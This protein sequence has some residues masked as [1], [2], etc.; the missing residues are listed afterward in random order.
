[1][2]DELDRVIEK[3]KDVSEETKKMS[4]SF[5]GLTDMTDVSSDSLNSMK[6][7]LKEFKDSISTNS[8]AMGISTAQT[9]LFNQQSTN[10][11]SLL[12]ALS[13]EIKANGTT[14]TSLMN[15]FQTAMDSVQSS[16]SGLMSNA[17][18]GERAEVLKKLYEDQSTKGGLMVQGLSS[19]TSAVNN[20]VPELGQGW[21]MIKNS[22]LITWAKSAT[23]PIARQWWM[24]RKERKL[25]KKRERAL[26]A[27]MN[28]E[29]VTW[30]TTDWL[31][32]KMSG[33]LGKDSWLGKEVSMLQEFRKKGMGIDGFEKLGAREVD[34]QLQKQISQLIDDQNTSKDALIATNEEAREKLA[35]EIEELQGELSVEVDPEEA[36]ALQE[37]ITAK[38]TQEQWRISNIAKQESQ[39]LQQNQEGLTKAVEELN[40]LTRG[41]EGHV[42]KTLEDVLEVNKE[43]F[44]GS[45]PYLQTIAETIQ[46]HTQLL[47]QTAEAGAGDGGPIPEGAT[48]DPP[49][50][51]FL[52]FLSGLGPAI[53][54]IP[55][56]IVKVLKGIGQ[57]IAG[58][59]KALGS[60]D[61]ASLAMGLAAIT[62]IALSMM[63]LAKALQIAGPVIVK[64]MGAIGKILTSV[65]EGY[66]KVIEA[67]GKVIVPILRAMA[68]VIKAVGGVVMKFFKGFATVINAIGSV[69]GGVFKGIIG[70]FKAIGTVIETIGRVI[71]T[72]GRVI[73][74][75][76]K[77]LVSS[78]IQLSEIPFWNYI[79]LAAAFVILGAALGIFGILAGVAV[80]PLIALG[81][82]SIGLAALMATIGDPERLSL[83]A[84][85]FNTLALAVTKFAISS[86][87][88][89]PALGIF[90]ALS[91]IPFIN[92]LIG[93]QEGIAK[94]QEVG[95]FTAET[96]VVEGMGGGIAQAMLQQQMTSEGLTQEQ[97]DIMPPGGQIITS[98]QTNI[99][100]R[101]TEV[102]VNKT[103]V[104]TNYLETMKGLNQVYA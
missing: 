59:F 31:F 36:A 73:I 67:A 71:V 30:D 89:I 62:G 98:N 16:A 47:E 96:L 34:T 14:T 35:S 93:T 97:G 4:D 3:L 12:N 103:A 42:E 100:N 80:V 61:P 45:P 63:M 19:M 50:P 21:D 41:Q 58:M 99:T 28:L 43:A 75:F 7:M 83:L 85:G 37:K 81:I 77:T 2:A 20:I 46:G 29:D 17:A 84:M 57:G 48:K 44:F 74:D 104:D 68:N 88:L 87:A 90:T 78:L 94:K 10:A 70:I 53:K 23:L 32:K 54:A 101:G 24:H 11:A 79:K 8:T 82:A 49:M 9:K 86:L 22:F 72:I 15:Q 39:K 1:M 52:G 102:H 55:G 13:G 40:S 60:I 26:A 51:N 91:A 27:G 76:I 64:I 69:I 65:F 5:S 95:T 18:G 25:L 6:V 38:Q 56:A 66:A 92:K 33:V